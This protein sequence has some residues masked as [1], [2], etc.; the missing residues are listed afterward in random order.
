[1]ISPGQ[2]RRGLNVASASFL[3]H[4]SSSHS[5]ACRHPDQLYLHMSYDAVS[6]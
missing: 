5:T 6:I 4:S 3:T 1:M 2:Q